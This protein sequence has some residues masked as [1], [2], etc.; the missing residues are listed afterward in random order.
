MKKVYYRKLI[1]DKVPDKILNKGSQIETR[2]LGQKEFELELRRKLVEESGGVE[3]ATTKKDI[4]TEL[5]DV[6]VVIDELKKT[7]KITPGEIAKAKKDNLAKKG[8]FKNKVYLV[9][10]SQDDYKTNEKLGRK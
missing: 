2:R 4:I 5:A 8:G 10:S 6:L 3:Q 7:Y 9:W 1:R